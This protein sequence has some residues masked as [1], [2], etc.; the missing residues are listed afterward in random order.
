MSLAEKRCALILPILRP[1]ARPQSEFG[2]F[3]SAVP[4]PSIPHPTA[5]EMA[6]DPG[7]IGIVVVDGR[8]YQSGNAAK[9]WSRAA[10]EV[11]KEA[12]RYSCLVSLIADN[13]LAAEGKTVPFNKEAA[14]SLGIEIAYDPGNVLGYGPIDISGGA[15]K[16]SG[17]SLELDASH[18]DKTRDQIQ[19]LIRMATLRDLA[20][21]ANKF[22]NYTGWGHWTHTEDVY[23]VNGA[24][25]SKVA[26]DL[27]FG[28][29]EI[30]GTKTGDDKV[31]EVLGHLNVSN[32]ADADAVAKM[33]NICSIWKKVVTGWGFDFSLDKVMAAGRVQEL[34][35]ALGV[36]SFIEAY[37]L[38]VPI[39]DVLA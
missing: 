11:C 19:D 7:K 6:S 8:Q 33:K 10:Y 4:S 23:R 27:T 28:A 36:D 17:S 24:N 34:G 20:I 21:T 5:E 3:R 13:T 14:S 9:H 16:I 37:L 26:A 32:L 31:M 29:W 25:I 22:I 1:G 38:G 12:D 18:L 2:A 15:L 30:E 35:H 39:E